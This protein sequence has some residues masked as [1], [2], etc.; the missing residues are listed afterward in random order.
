MHDSWVY[1][2]EMKNDTLVAK[3]GILKKYEHCFL[4]SRSI[5]AELGSGEQ[6]G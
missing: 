2:K 5:I 6:Q 1:C 4:N 3:E